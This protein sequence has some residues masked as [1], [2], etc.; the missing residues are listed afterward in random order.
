MPDRKPM[1]TV[2]ELITHAQKKGIKFEIMSTDEAKSYL[3][4]R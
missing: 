3:R 4:K 1:L 2:D